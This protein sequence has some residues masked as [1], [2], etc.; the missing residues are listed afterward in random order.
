MKFFYAVILLCT[1]H[2]AY[3]E[4]PDELTADLHPLGVSMKEVAPALDKLM[5][6]ND[7]DERFP[8]YTVWTLHGQNDTSVYITH[9]SHGK[10]YGAFFQFY[11][12]HDPQREHTYD[13]CLPIAR[14]LILSLMRD[15]KPSINEIDKALRDLEKTKNTKTFREKDRVMYFRYKR[16]S[17][18]PESEDGYRCFRIEIGDSSRTP[19]EDT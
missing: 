17:S 6:R 18:M 2:R 16:A 8:H 9:D 10:I 13:Q 7:P 14:F 12:G 11:L 5:E 15:N 19:S 3:C 1:L 4:T